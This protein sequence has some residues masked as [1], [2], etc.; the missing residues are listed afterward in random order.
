MDQLD[1][2][3]GEEKGGEDYTREGLCHGHMGGETGGE[4]ELSGRHLEGRFLGS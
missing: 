3:R 2:G 1:G 4:G